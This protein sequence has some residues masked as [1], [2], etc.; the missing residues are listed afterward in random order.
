VNT[1]LGFSYVHYDFQFD[2]LRGGSAVDERTNRVPPL[3]AFTLGIST[4]IPVD[5]PDRLAFGIGLFLPTRSIANVTARA[6]SSQPEW[7][8]FGTSQD[9]LQA[10]PAMA[11]KIL[12]EPALYV[13]GGASIFAAADGSTQADIGPPIQTTFNLKLKPSAGGIA[14]VYFA[15]A[16][17]MS[18]GLTYRS[19][20]SFKLDFDVQPTFLS[21][22]QTPIRIQA[23]SYFTPHQVSF[24]SSFDV[25]E[26][27][28]VALDFTYLNW[29]SFREP[30]IVTSSPA[31]PVPARAKGN[32]HD[33]V[34]PRL[35]LEVYPLQWLTLR[36]GYFYRM[37]PVGSQD[38]KTFNLVDSDEHVF[39]LGVGFEY[40]PG[41]AD[42][43][44]KEGAPKTTLET[45]TFGLDL[46]F[47][48][49]FLSGNS[50]SKADPADPIGGWDAGGQIYHFGLAFTGR[51]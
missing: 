25:G 20:R 4:T 6:P 18:F 10:I 41:P 26:Y 39:S 48:A 36:G 24:G 16:K 34:I 22:I 1:S 17:W 27:A 45:A 9:R 3:S 51:F 13:G 30:F 23:L 15:P 14:G 21:S 37:S 19:E 11:V 38:K 42:K 44:P 33:T 46:F 32:F 7:T 8:L 29:G 43:T 40:S 31:I 28:L 5:Q 50:S 2:S 49:H 35:G 12:D 47:Q